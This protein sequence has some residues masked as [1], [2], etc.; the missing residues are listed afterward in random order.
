MNK[1]SPR[2]L[3]VSI[4]ATVA[5]LAE[6]D[7]LADR[8]LGTVLYLALKMGRP[9]FLEGEAGV[10]K[11]EIA[12]VLSTTLG[13]RLIRLQCYEGL[14]VGAAVYEWNYAAQMIAI[15]VAEAEGETVETCL[16]RPVDKVGG[17]HAIAGNRREHHDAAVPLSPEHSRESGHR[18]AWACEVRRGQRRELS[19]VE[20]GG[21]A[22]AAHTGGDK[23]QVDRAESLDGQVGE[24]L[25]GPDVGDVKQ[26]DL[27]LVDPQAVKVFHRPFEALD[28][29]ASE[30]DGAQLT[31]CQ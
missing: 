19:G 30:E 15:R 29:P 8:S 22:R 17:T 2:P 6:A 23:N 20:A 4:D 12:K 28:T 1:T 31:R 14:D 7:Y 13:R 26:G 9:L 3:P 21:L 16:G 27:D 24:V 18:R 25:Q 10:G 11:T 5:L